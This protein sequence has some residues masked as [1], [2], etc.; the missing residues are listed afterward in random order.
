MYAEAADLYKN[1]WQKVITDYSLLSHAANAFYQSAKLNDAIQAYQ[2]LVEDFSK[3]Q[4]EN[5]LH[6]ADASKANLNFREAASAYKNYYKK[7]SNKSAEKP[8]IKNEIL[9]CLEGIRINR[10]E[11]VAIVESI[12]ANI[13]SP[14]EEYNIIPSINYEDRFYFSAI[15]SDNEGGLRDEQGIVDS[16]NGTIRS[17]LFI[18]EKQNGSWKA[19]K[20]MNTLI[21]GS[22]NDLILDFMQDGASMIYF[23]SWNGKEGEIKI[24]SLLESNESKIP[25]NFFQGLL[26]GEIGD[27]S[28]SIYQDSV[29]IFSSKRLGGYGGYDLYISIRRN[30]AW[31]PA[32]N[33]GPKINTPYNEITP[34]IAKDGHSLYFSSDNLKS[35][36]GYDIFKTR[37][38]AESAEWNNPENVGLPVNSAANDISFRLTPNGISGVFTSD[39]IKDS[40]GKQDIFI[41]YFKEELEEQF[42]EPQGTILSQLFNQIMIKNDNVI[43]RNDNIKK[44]SEPKIYKDYILESI[45]YTDEKFIKDPKTLKIIE[46]VHNMMKVNPELKVQLYGHAYEDNANPL[47]LYY[48]IKRAEQVSDKLQ[49][50]GISK[51]KI[52]VYGLGNFFPI[53][54]TEVNNA[55]SSISDKW[56]KRIDWNV[57]TEDSSIA[58]ISYPNPIIP[59]YLRLSNNIN[60]KKNFNTLS[61]SIIIGESDQILN[62][63]ILKQN[64]YPVFV[65]YNNNLKKYQYFIGMESKFRDILTIQKKIDNNNRYSIIPMMNGIA[66]ERKNII[67][68]VEKFPDLIL[69]INYVNNQK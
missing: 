46:Q 67:F 16:K 48:S 18:A 10:F 8:K 50:L 12:G 42:Y 34:F 11:P 37:F 31:L 68:H 9:R 49:E 24:H 39:R 47:N 6:L 15:R 28:L 2:I 58:R 4:K 23:Q 65:F 19:L 61:Y 33:L 13:N 35:I 32:K 66:I 43:T 26:Y 29:I 25:D 38:K 1:A 7:L 52:S 17:D 51:N 30:N 62:S 54:K 20:K 63:D 44:S 36:G 22:K 45:Y 21:N 3:N 53:A 64:D 40:K 27:A 55:K 69:Y 5:L 41:A 60:P 56:N 14:N 57:L 59:E